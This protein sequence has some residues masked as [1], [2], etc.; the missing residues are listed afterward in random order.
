MSYMFKFENNLKV[1]VITS[2]LILLFTVNITNAKSAPES[3]ADLAEE[4][5]VE[6]AADLM[7]QTV[8]LTDVPFA[9]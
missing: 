4:L 7:A 8:T 9:W 3:F 1:S 6:H 5:S 2:L